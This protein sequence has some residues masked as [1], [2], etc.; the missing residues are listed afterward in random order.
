M[1]IYNTLSGK[2]EKLIIPKKGGLK[3]F[4]CGPTVYNES[5]IGHARTYLVFDA[6]VKYLRSQKIKISYLQNITDVDD[7]IIARAKQTKTSPKKIADKY[8]ASYLKDMKMLEIESVDTYARATRYIPEIVKQV[9]TLIKKGH[10]YEIK[11]DGWYFDIATFPDYGKL[12]KRTA[13]QAEDA[14]TRI[15]ESVRKK[16]RGDFCV[17]KFSKSGE[18]VWQTALGAGRPG[19][20][21]EDTAIAEKFFGP[22]YDLHGGGLDL[23]FPHH[24]AEIAQA[25]A[26]SDKKPFVK[27][28]LHT[29][30]LTVNGKKMSKSLRNFISITDFS[31][32][33][34]PELLRWIVLNHHY[35]SPINYTEELVKQTKE[36]LDAIK[37]FLAKLD[38]VS[39]IKTKKTNKEIIGAGKLN[40]I[41]AAALEDNFNTPRAL[42]AL[43]NFLNR[44]NKN[45]WFFNQ[46]TALKIKNLINAEIAMLGL[47]IK[48]EAVPKNITKLANQRELL[49]ANKQF[50]RADALRKKLRVLGYE[51]EDTP[52]GPFIKAVS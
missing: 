2:K 52:L 34:K 7:K 17:W 25:E 40:R 41:F 23:K 20:H 51:I 45:I 18:P 35:R 19:W 49:R 29:G 6:F 10:V 28:W 1:F 50:I 13:A 38:F 33:Y 21:I 31:K 11:N 8:L 39:A 30:M 48:K 46:E 32:K 43:F 16:N 14:I 42:A 4:V 37:E 9:Q 5:H 12:S 15:D 36:S 3:L 47:K 44:N 26:A 22:Q 24:E 27:I